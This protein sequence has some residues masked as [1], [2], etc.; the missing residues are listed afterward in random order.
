MPKVSV[1]VPIYNVEKYLNQCIDSILSQTLKDIEIILL[2]D[3]STDSS[4]KIC[5]EYSTKDKRIKVIHKE[6]SGYGATMNIGLK[7]AA[8]EYIGIVESDDWADATMFE[9]LYSLATLHN[10]DVVK[11]NFYHYW[12]N[13]EKNE[14]FTA[15]PSQDTNKIINP[16]ENPAIFSS[17]PSIWA[18]IY[19][20]KFLI[21]NKINFL[22]TPGASYQDT[23]FNF[24]VWATTQKAWLTEDAFLHYRQDN[25][26]SSVKSKGKTFC[27]C[28]EFLEIEKFTKTNDLDTLLPLAQKLKFT[29][30]IW[31]FRRLIWPQNFKFFLRMKK[32][33]KI[34]QKHNLL[35][36]ILFGENYIWIRRI[37]RHPYKFFIKHL[38]KHMEK[39]ANA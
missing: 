34:A 30:Y 17:C 36:P 23:G 22:E 6:N 32:E 13:P 29:T 19:N 20:R 15:L 33:L 25:E 4:P 7:E 39:Q 3:G 12:S 21:D 16:Q 14:L 1:L 8:G 2:D 38:I 11:S 5:D 28:D 31:N 26:Q 24:K 18:A 27:I 10:V 9:K 35:D 37:L